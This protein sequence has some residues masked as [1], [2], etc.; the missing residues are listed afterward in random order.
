MAAENWEGVIAVASDNRFVV[1]AS[2]ELLWNSGWANFQIER[3][4]AA[5]SELR[6]A[7]DLGPPHHANYMALGATL[8]RMAQYDEA[9]L[10]LLRA[11]AIRNAFTTRATLALAYQT[12][13]LLEVA[14][15]V[16]KEGM[17]THPTRR[18]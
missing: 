18:A 7:I 2:S 3:Y 16:H 11:L 5:E 8:L 15:E 9:E 17:R 6:K 14:E 12:Q 4:S 10:W 13:G 1:E